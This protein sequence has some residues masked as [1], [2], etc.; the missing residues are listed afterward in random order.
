[1]AENIDMLP[2]QCP[3]ESIS[4]CRPLK[5]AISVPNPDTEIVQHNMNLLLD[6]TPSDLN[7]RKGQELQTCIGMNSEDCVRSFSNMLRC[8]RVL[9][10]D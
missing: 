5:K 9:E 6:A 3:P 8:V 7:S 2:P 1:M 10:L 4:Y